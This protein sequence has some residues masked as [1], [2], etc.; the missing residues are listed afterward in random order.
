MYYPRILLAKVPAKAHLEAAAAFNRMIQD[1]MEQFLESKGVLP[2]WRSIKK[3][4][5]DSRENN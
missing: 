5:L 2:I 1:Y 4:S 3:S